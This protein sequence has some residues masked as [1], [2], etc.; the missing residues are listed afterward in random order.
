VPLSPCKG[1]LISYRDDDDDDD[2]YFLETGVNT[3]QNRYKMY[4][5]ILIVSSTVTMVSAVQDDCS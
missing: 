4:N 1:R 5:L 2:D 3:P